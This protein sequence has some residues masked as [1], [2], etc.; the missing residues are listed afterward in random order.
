MQLELL[1]LAVFKKILTE[2]EKTCS[3]SEGIGFPYN[4]MFFSQIWEML[5]QEIWR[6]VKAVDILKTFIA[7]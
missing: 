3:M 5:M 1:K 2:F 7:L 6:E 4:Y